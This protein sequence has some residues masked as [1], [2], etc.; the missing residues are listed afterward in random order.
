MCRLHPDDPVL[1]AQLGEA[2]LKHGHEVGGTLLLREAYRMLREEN[3]REARRLVERFGDAV[4]ADAMRPLAHTDYLPLAEGMDA[5][6]RRRRTVR[7][8]EGG[9][10]FRVGDP[11]DAA[12]LVLEGKLAVVLPEGRRWQLL[13]HL[14]AGALV[15]EGALEPGAKRTATVIANEPSTLLRF[16]PDELR[17]ALG[18]HP[19]LNLRFSK[20]ALWRRRVAL[21]ST[22]P[23]FARLPMDV[24][25]LVA[26]QV[27]EQTHEAGDVIKE[28]GALLPCTALLAEGVARLHEGRSGTLYVGRLKPGTLIGVHHWSDYDA[29]SIR[30]TAETD[31]RLLCMD[32]SV[33]EDLMDASSW[34]AAQIREAGR[35]LAVRLQATMKWHQSGS[36]ETTDGRSG[37]HGE[38]GRPGA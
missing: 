36:G 7:L 29:R 9:T 30:I 28:R 16:E 38:G 10:L 12:Y 25:F 11:A 27:W 4:T 23:L 26:R 17:R 5:R 1:R 37:A 18:A 20:E 2:L 15:G 35:A 6:T 8:Q 21:L 31:C 24:R 13:N 14:H 19:E 3:P 33:I 22:V 34:F 32:P